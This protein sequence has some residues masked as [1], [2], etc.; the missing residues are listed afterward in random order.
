MA[1]STAM[2]RV[3]LPPA[4]GGMLSSNPPSSLILAPFSKSSLWQ[5][6]PALD[7]REFSSRKPSTFQYNLCIRKLALLPWVHQDKLTLWTAEPCHCHTDWSTRSKRHQALDFSWRQGMAH[8]PFG[9]Y[10]QF[11]CLLLL[12]AVWFSYDLCF[13]CSQKT[14]M[15]DEVYDHMTPVVFPLWHSRFSFISILLIALLKFS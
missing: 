8:Q 4:L 15:L 14:F 12:L 7:R 5:E 10:P 2:T 11:R 13:C 9:A 1:F 3:K 6:L